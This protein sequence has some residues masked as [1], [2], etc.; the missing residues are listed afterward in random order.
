MTMTFEELVR[1]NIVEQER[2][3]SSPEFDQLYVDVSIPLVI[4]D[5]IP[6]LPEQRGYIE[7]D[8]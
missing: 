2:R 1:F 7:I 4:P 6:E 5:S 8:M 3:E